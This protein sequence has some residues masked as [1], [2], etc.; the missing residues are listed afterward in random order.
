MATKKTS[1]GLK[2]FLNETKRLR[3]E[4]ILA[5]VNGKPTPPSLRSEYS[6]EGVS[7]LV[8]KF[9]LFLKEEGIKADSDKALMFVY[10]KLGGAIRTHVA[11]KKPKIEPNEDDPQ[12]VEDED[13]EGGDEEAEEKDEE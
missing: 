5:V 2:V 10:T 3:A 6:P 7:E 12:V 9:T 11:S 8:E 1:T 13:E 4:G